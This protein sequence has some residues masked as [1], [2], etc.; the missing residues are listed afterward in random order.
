MYF[1]SPVL[2]NFC[3]KGSRNFSPKQLFLGIWTLF[4]AM[5]YIKEMFLSKRETQMDHQLLIYK[6][7]LQSGLIKN[8]KKRKLLNFI[9]SQIFAWNYAE[10]K[11]CAIFLYINIL[12][13][14][15]FSIWTLS[16]LSC[17]GL[18]F[19]QIFVSESLV[20]CN[21]PIKDLFNPP[22]EIFERE[23]GSKYWKEA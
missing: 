20:L 23:A 7:A 14:L 21:H 8:Q 17:P 4:S 15:V 13:I 19:N 22:N 9:N 5:F 18:W 12:P 6:I 10:E 11:L 2:A 1:S 3:I 16:D